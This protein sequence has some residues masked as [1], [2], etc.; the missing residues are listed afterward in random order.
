MINIILCTYNRAYNLPLIFSSLNDQTLAPNIIL[1]LLNNKIE[2]RDIIEKLTK[3]NYNFKIKLTH[4]DNTNNIFERFLYAK[5]LINHNPNIEHLI[6]IDD[7]MIYQNDWVEKMYNLRKPKNFITW[8][9]KLY[10]LNDKKINYDKSSIITNT[11]C[12][13]DLKKK[14]IYG[15]YGAPCGCIID[16]SIFKDEYFFKIPF[17]N[18]KYMDDIWLSYYLSHIKRW[19]IKRSF[20]PPKLIPADHP[21]LYASKKRE[22]NIFFKFLINN[23]GWNY[24]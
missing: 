19:K 22:K 15:N 23:M 14:F 17:P 12:R 9:V 10:N 11:D 4:Y 18:V 16:S 24:E 3:Y 20:L 1:H 21:T 6:F 13:N 5:Y 2:D 8:Y 7:D